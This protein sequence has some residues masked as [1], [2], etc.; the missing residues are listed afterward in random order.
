VC[1]WSF[2][3]ILLFFICISFSTFSDFGSSSDILVD[4]LVVLRSVYDD[5]G[6]AHVGDCPRGGHTCSS[7]LVDGCLMMPLEL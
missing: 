5:G 6:G 4:T 1:V 2:L 3:I 7:C